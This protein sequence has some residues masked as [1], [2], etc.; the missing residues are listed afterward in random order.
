MKTHIVILG[1]FLLYTASIYA[2]KHESLPADSLFWSVPAYKTEGEYNEAHRQHI[3][4]LLA[5][6]TPEQRVAQTLLVSWHGHKPSSEIMRW[7]QN[8]NIGGIKVFGWNG[9]D[10]PALVNAIATMQHASIHTENGI[11]LFTA[12]DQEGGWVRH[13]KG[14][15][16]QTSGNM[17]IGAL[18]ASVRCD[19]VCTVYWHGTAAAWH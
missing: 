18:A 11:P 9:K 3:E 14:D 8:R 5:H 16:S 13:V 15:T 2:Q 4:H 12:T 10:L 7:I 19:D 6:M 1:F 17:A